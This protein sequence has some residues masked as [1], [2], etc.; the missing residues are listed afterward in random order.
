[1][2]GAKERSPSLIRREASVRV[3][4]EGGERRNLAGHRSN[5]RLCDSTARES[6]DQFQDL[7]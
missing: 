2:G 3:T 7:Q 1:M 5:S 6:R 4:E